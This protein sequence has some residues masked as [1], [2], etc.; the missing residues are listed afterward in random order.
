MKRK[1]T[2]L[3]PILIL[4]SLLLSSCIGLIPLEKDEPATGGYGP[5]ISSQEHQA[6]TFEAL[7]KIIQDNYIYYDTAGVDWSTLH[8][9]YQTE[10]KKGLT[11]EEFDALIK[12]LEAD[13]PESS[14]LYQSRA[15]RIETEIADNSTYEGIGAFI[16][17]NPEPKPHIILL[18]IIEGSPAEKAGLKA[19]D[20]ILAIDGNPVLM[21]E[22]TSAVQRVRGPSGSS[23]TLTIQSPGETERAVEVQRGKLAATVSLDAHRIAGT[24]FGYLLFPPTSYDN[25]LQDVLAAMQEFTTNQ[26]L[27]G[28]IIDLRIAGSSG[29]WP[30]EN[31]YT[32]FSD[33]NIGDFYNRTNK[34][35]IQVQGQ[36]VFN[37]Q[38]V[39]LVILVGQN[40]Q[41]FPEVFAG[42][43][44][45]KKRAV[46]IGQATNG[47]VETSTSYPLPD[48]SR[49]FV[50]TT[51]FVLP[52]GDLIGLDGIKPDLQIEAGWDE[53]ISTKDP[54]LDAAIQELESNK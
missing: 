6:Q 51:S 41:G 1:S 26:T 15:D 7:W 18:S 24:H 16:G 38:T 4:L 47:T 22:G 10:I 46:V 5:Q 2:V 45:V 34:Q 19:H 43:L 39:P 28:L 52:N 14:I 42:S 36:D 53:V 13:L 37:S 48:G 21:E 9:E 54:V 31:L 49:V 30:L 8:T 25:L 11:Q 23:V 27:E 33:G 50:E 35:A 32:M 40:T 29:N 20:S 12:N 44:Q 17:F 3:F